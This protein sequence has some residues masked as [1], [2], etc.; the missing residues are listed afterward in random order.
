[1]TRNFPATQSK[2]YQT[3]LYMYTH[4]FVGRV[5][6]ENLLKPKLDPSSQA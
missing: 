4:C 5:F 6:G 2:S 1:M 3:L